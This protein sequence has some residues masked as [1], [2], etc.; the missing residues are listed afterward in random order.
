MKRIV[1][2]E[3]SEIFRLIIEHYLRND[4]YKV[5]VFVNGDEAMKYMANNPFDMLITDL[6]MPLKDG[7]E[8]IREL[9]ETISKTVPVM[10]ISM[11][12]DPDL[13]SHIL[14]VGA[15]D[16]L[17]KPFNNGQL[18]VHVHRLLCKNRM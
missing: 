18:R 5:E 16:Y 7:L 1:V 13:I 8:L 2:A 3:D 17:K 14:D 9:R 4:G 6:D 15:D 10:V 11:R 12:S